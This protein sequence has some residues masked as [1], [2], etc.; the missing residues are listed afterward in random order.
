MYKISFTLKQHTPLIHFQHEQE[1]ATLRATEVKPKLDRFIIDR[2]GGKLNVK[3][4][5]FNNY[6]RESLNYQLKI[7]MPRA[8]QY[9]LPLSLH[10]NSRSNPHRADK[11]VEQISNELGIDV[12]II[13]P[14]PFFG[15]NDKY[16]FIRQNDNLDPDKT[17]LKELK[18]GI[19]TD[20]DIS[21]QFITTNIEFKEI[22]DK[23]LSDFFITQ[24]FGTRQSKGF[25]SFTIKSDSEI[26]TNLLTVIKTLPNLE[27]VYSKPKNRS[28]NLFDDINDFWEFLKAGDSFREYK[29][30][31]IFHFYYNQ[32]PEKVRWEKRAIKQSIKANQSSVWDELKPGPNLNR[33][34]T[35]FDVQD[36]HFYVRAL[37]GLAEN[38]EYGTTS[39]NTVKV[40]IADFLSKSTN[41][42]EKDKAVD[43]FQSPITIKVI[44][45]K[46]YLFVYKIPELL[47]VDKDKRDREFDFTLNATINN[48][49]YRQLLCSLGVPKDF[50]V[51]AFLDSPKYD[52]ATGLPKTNKN[53]IAKDFGYTKLI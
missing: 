33:I 3:K 21:I 19:S 11:L 9:Y 30:S 46:I 13:A 37:L 39:R 6:D 27:S 32:K 1:G 50:S 22:F 8:T 20:E 44:G 28:K 17:K 15:N 52:T 12:E 29:K 16:H 14:S 47:Q 49:D 31:D 51:T 34:V 42:L 38:N 43:R 18:F 4:S 23:H 40:T 36:N 2:L 41:Q 25:G 35:E 48:I 10:P 26:P 7:Q 24:N 5:L 45:D 53:S